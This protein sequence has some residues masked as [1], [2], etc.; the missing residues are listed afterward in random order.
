[1]ASTQVTG[2]LCIRSRPNNVHY[3]GIHYQ[4]AHS[5][6]RPQAPILTALP[7]SSCILLN[8]SSIAQHALMT[9]KT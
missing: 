1:M 5:K 7:T 4:D 3:Q 2:R 6:Y 9:A 8:A